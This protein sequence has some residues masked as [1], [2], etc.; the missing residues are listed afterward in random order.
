MRF[1]SLRR[2]G[3]HSLRRR[4]GEP[5]RD[6]SAGYEVLFLRP[7]GQPGT[8]GLTEATTQDTAPGV[9]AISRQS[10][11]R[12]GTGMARMRR[13]GFAVWRTTFSAMLPMTNR[14][15]PLRPW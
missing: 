3:L 10:S 4:L 2:G 14:S 13:T 11:G 12:G 7:D 5:R 8:P 9:D 6:P 1:L 15:I